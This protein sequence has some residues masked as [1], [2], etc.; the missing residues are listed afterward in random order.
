MSKEICPFFEA[1]YWV[2]YT[3]FVVPI[4]SGSTEIKTAGRI[5]FVIKTD[6]HPALKLC[7][8]KQDF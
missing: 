2:R 7:G 1:I 4:C 5:E 3:I 6:K 8:W